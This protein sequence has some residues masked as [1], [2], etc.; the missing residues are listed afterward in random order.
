M[1]L[2]ISLVAFLVFELLCSITLS[3]QDQILIRQ[4]V[5]PETSEH[6]AIHFGV[7]LPPSYQTK[8]K[9]YPVIYYLHGLN[10][11]YSDWKAQI[12]AEFFAGLFKEGEIQEFILVFPDGGEGFWGDHY[13][14]EP[15][16]E[17]EIVDFL[18]PYIDQLYPVNA[19]KR[20][21]MGWSAGGAGAMAIFSK[22]P[23]LFK[24]IISLDGSIT[25]WEEFMYFQGE[26]PDIAN[27]SD[28]FYENF[29]PS[30]W[31]VRNKNIIKEKQDTA[32]FLSAALFADSHQNFLKILHDQ[33]IPFIYKE[34]ECNHEFGCVF[35]EIRND[36]L[37]FLSMILD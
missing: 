13:D 24:A 29:S 4:S 22:H 3:A 30:K 19:D 33:G 16:L 34:L 20:L 2:S 7:M 18:I 23:K 14:R 1:K 11:H 36:L 25:T 8:D 32:I 28:Y 9:Y 12:V 37:S 6:H 35:S 21:I 10:G 5:I 31:V 15:L 17:K 26:K 27:N